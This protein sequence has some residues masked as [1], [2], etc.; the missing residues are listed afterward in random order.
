VILVT[1]AA[2]KTG[3]TVLRALAAVGAPARALIHEPDYADRVRDAG[4]SEVLLGNLEQPADMAKALKD[5]ETLYL[6]IP[7]MHPREVELGQRIVAQAAAAGLLRLVYHS[8]LYP[9]V[10]AMPHHWAKL[11]VEEAL[12]ASGMPFT[13]LQPAAYMQNILAYWDAIVNEGRYQL[14]Y[15]V[16]ALSSPVDLDDVA[17]VAAKVLIEDSYEH[18]SFEL[19]GPQMLSASEQAA[20]IGER[21]GKQVAVQA[22]SVEEWRQGAGSLPDYARD[23]LCHMFAY[24]D[25]HSFI[26]NGAVL[27]QLLGRPPTSFRQF[28]ARIN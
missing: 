21:L 20:Q 15:S 16:D 8:V 2:G 10:E 1:G 13:I 7:N 19:C 24:Y 11:R 25:Q 4:A 6:I 9:Q 22:V 14:P 28:L 3:L 27:E 23:T 12:I 26:G 18:A 17:E 5:V